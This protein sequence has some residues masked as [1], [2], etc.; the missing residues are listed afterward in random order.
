M[1]EPVAWREWRCH[2]GVRRQTTFFVTSFTSMSSAKSSFV[3]GIGQKRNQITISCPLVPNKALFWWI[4]NGRRPRMRDGS[5]PVWPSVLL[6]FRGR[7]QS[8]DSKKFQIS[9]SLLSSDSSFWRAFNNQFQICGFNVPTFPSSRCP[10][11]LDGHGYLVADVLI[12]LFP[13]LALRVCPPM[14]DQTK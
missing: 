14:L 10:R 13:L 11:H 5:F 1:I 9:L 2:G 8:A 7:W 12:V 3:A 6:H 4:H